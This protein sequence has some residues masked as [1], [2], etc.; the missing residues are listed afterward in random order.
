MQK[1]RTGVVGHGKLQRLFGC[2][3]RIIDFM[4]FS[5]SE[6]LKPPHTQGEGEIKCHQMKNQR[7][8]GHSLNPPQ[9]VE[10]LNCKLPR[11]P[12]SKW[13]KHQWEFICSLNEKDPAGEP[14]FVV[15]CS[16]L[17]LYFWFSFCWIILRL[18]SYRQNKTVETL[19][20]MYVHRA[21]QTEE[22]GSLSTSQQSSE[23]PSD[24]MRLRSRDLPWKPGV[25]RLRLVPELPPPSQGYG[26]RFLKAQGP[27]NRNLGLWVR[28]MTA[29]ETATKP[30]T[31]TQGSFCQ[32]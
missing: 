31:K 27:P 17:W 24:W 20:P 25:G 29:S 23:A 3:L 8:C 2:R 1:E 19:G 30:T 11:S 12:T 4:L 10:S 15:V 9:S 14:N 16:E 6:S 7:I 5:G 26:G 32:L 13:N 22:H 28:G 18:V 21:F